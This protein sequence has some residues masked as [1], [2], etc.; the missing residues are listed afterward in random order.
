M[1]P[2][3]SVVIAV[4]APILANC[5]THP[6]VDDVTR[7]TTFDVVQKIRCEAKRA[8]IAHGQA[9]GNDTV[10]AYEFTFDVDEKNSASGDITW[11]LPVTAGTFSLSATAGSDLERHA[12]RNF[13]IVD[14]F[15]DLRRTDCSPEALEKNWSYPIAGEIG[16][17]EV[18]AT[19]AQLPGVAFE[20]ESDNTFSYHDTLRFTTFLGAGVRPTLTLDQLTDRS[21]VSLAKADLSAGRLDIHTVVIAFAGTRPTAPAVARASPTSSRIANIRSFRAMRTNGAVPNAAVTHNIALATTLLQTG[22]DPRR[23]VIHELD[24]A[25][26]LALQDRVR[27]QV[28][29]P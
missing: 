6:L 8:I 7:S 15:G 29:G 18:V 10:I 2:I 19:F 14:T 20:S 3:H 27:N 23:N 26:I 17:Y 5:S 16:I 22:N 9:F 25:R 24:R 11:T 1:R 12:Q 28:V 4:L 21:R 13:T